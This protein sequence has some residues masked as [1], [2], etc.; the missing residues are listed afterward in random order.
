MSDTPDKN[1]LKRRLREATAQ[2]RTALVDALPY[3]V[4]F[5]KPPRETRFKPGKSG[6]RK[7]RPKGRFNM[8]TVL[9]KELAQKVE[10]N[11]HGRR[12]RLFK[13]QVGLR[14]L[15]NKAAGGDVKA[16]TVAIELLRKLGKLQE[17]TGPSAPA[18]D[19]R[20]LEALSG[21]LQFFQTANLIEDGGNTGAG[22]AAE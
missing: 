14:Q 1:N 16:L 22:G 12:Q 18:V 8:S 19:F 20:D 15:L 17:A 2:E 10:V 13:T 5:G 3:D 4:G 7:G 9:D 6:N 21:I 11:D